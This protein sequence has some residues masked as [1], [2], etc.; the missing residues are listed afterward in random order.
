ME[1]YSGYDFALFGVSMPNFWLG[2]LL[3][4]VF[5]RNGL[6]GTKELSWS[7]IGRR[8]RRMSGHGEVKG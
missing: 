1:G 2:L 5:F 7:A 4:I 6:F 3:I 8:L